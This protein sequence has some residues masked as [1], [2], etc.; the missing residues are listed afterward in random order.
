MNELETYLKQKGYI[1]FQSV[2]EFDGFCKLLLRYDEF[3][4]HTVSF[5]NFKGVPVMFNKTL[6]YS[7]GRTYE[8][9]SPSGSL[10]IQN[11]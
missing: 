3:V 10:K 4:D 9:K 6:L 5:S 8:K 2:E 7:D 1:V 11:A